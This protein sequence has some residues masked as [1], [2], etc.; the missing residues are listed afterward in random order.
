MHGVYMQVYKT[1]VILDLHTLH[2]H[3]RVINVQGCHDNL[4]HPFRP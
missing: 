3:T 2:E 1:K 4:R